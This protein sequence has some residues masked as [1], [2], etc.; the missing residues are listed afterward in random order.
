MT[1]RIEFTT[2]LAKVLPALGPMSKPVHASSLE[3]TLLELVA[4]R[5]S[6]LNGC[7][8]CLDMHSKD[9]RAIGETEQR[10]YVLHA[11]REAPFYSARERAALEW[12]EAL[13][14]I[15]GRDVPDELFAAVR[16]QFSE[17]ELLA[18]S[19]AILATNCY[20]RLNIAFR[21]EVGFYQP[22]MFER[23]AALAARG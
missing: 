5:T 3:R 18:L 15:A 1:A 7:A 20:N 13:T 10:L 9:A 16:A 11:W 19:L 2:L 4:M 23:P 22:G 6:Q 8:F 14:M 12:T 17:D 21:T